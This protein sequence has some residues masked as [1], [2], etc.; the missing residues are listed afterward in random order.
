M[1]VSLEQVFEQTA[2][3]CVWSSGPFTAA[4]WARYMESFD[5]VLVAARVKAVG[6]P[7]P[8]AHV[9][10]SDRVTFLK[11]PP[12][13]GFAG[14]VRHAVAIRRAFRATIQPHD[15]VILRIPSP[16]AVCAISAMRSQARPYAVEVVG[17]AYEV[18][19]PASYRHSL[20]PVLRWLLA[21]SQ[22]RQCAGAAL[23]AYVTREV[24]Q[25]RYPCGPGT[26]AADAVGADAARP[27]TTHYSSVELPA[28]AFAAPK[29][30]GPSSR[31]V[32]LVTVGTLANL[33]KGTDLLIRAFAQSV[34]RGGALIELTIVGEGRFREQFE[35]LCRG[36]KVEH[37]VHFAGQVEGHDAVMAHLDRSDLFVLA[38][39]TEGLPRA[40]IE[41]MARGL[42]CI[43]S[44]VGGIPEL[45]TAEDMF[46]V[47]SVDGLATKIDEMVSSPARRSTAGARNREIAGSY[48]Q[49]V[50]TG[51]R[52]QFYAA[53]RT[54][55]D[56]WTANR[57]TP[58]SEAA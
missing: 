54:R 44:R 29:R 4:F 34:G 31:P 10:S 13:E 28:A 9:V 50:L 24:L 43:G 35:A 38:S 26:G 23:A 52:R 12:Y 21:R 1:V 41:A 17:D 55:T 42:P 2:D 57:T 3:G 18:L 22:R 25:A 19:A 14:F 49:Q 33:Y 36:L 27:F 51:R 56:Q 37:L 45:L 7:R 53:V 30:H 11:L 32:R 58:A 39:R 48:S 16:I 15:A 8:G 5:R 6:E 40:M 47:G 46:E 20:R